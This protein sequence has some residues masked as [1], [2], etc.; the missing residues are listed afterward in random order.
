MK[1]VFLRYIAPIAIGLSIPSAI[2]AASA[3]FSGPTT[4]PTGGNVPGVIWNMV[5]GGTQPGAVINIDGAASMGSANIAGQAS[6]GNIMTNTNDSN[7]RKNI[8]IQP[9]YAFHVDQNSASTYNMGNWGGLGGTSKPMTF[10]IYGGARSTSIPMPNSV[11]G[12]D[13]RVQADKFCFNPGNPAD[14][15]FSWS[16]ASGNFVVKTGDTMTGS[17]IINSA[18]TKPLTVTGGAINTGAINGTNSV[19]NGFGGQ[20]VGNTAVY[21]SST[22]AVGIGVEGLG[23]DSGAG[24]YGLAPST[25]VGGYF[26]G[27]TGA[28]VQGTQDGLIVT[29]PSYYGVYAND[30]GN[31]FGVVGRGTIAGGAFYNGATNNG[32][33]IGISGYALDASGTTRVT[34]ST[35]GTSVILGQSLPNA[36]VTNGALTVKGGTTDSGAQTLMPAPDGKNYIRG[37][38]IFGDV[39]HNH[40]G[41][42]LSN[43]NQALYIADSNNGIVYGMKLDNYYGAGTITPG[44]GVG[45]LFSVQG[46]GWNLDT[47]RGKGAIVYSQTD[48]WGRGAISFLQNSSADASNPTLANAV[49]TIANNGSVGI[50]SAP[51]QGQLWVNKSVAGGQGGDVWISNNAASTLGNT[52]RLAFGVD[53]STDPTPNGGIEDIMT[54]T[55]SGAS[56]MSF[57]TWNGSSYGERMRIGANGNVGIGIAPGTNQLLVA[58]NSTINCASGFYNNAYNAGAQFGCPIKTGNSY[59]S[60]A[61][62]SNGNRV[63]FAGLDGSGVA[64]ALNVIGTVNVFGTAYKSTGIS[65]VNTSDIRLKDHVE[66]MPYGLDE[67]A[68][69]HVI[70]Y[71]FKPNNPEN[72]PSDQVHF[73]MSAQEV[74]KV[75][76]EA[77]SLDSQGYYRLDADPIIWTSVNAIK[78]LKAE[79]DTL[80]AKYSELEQRLN[81]LQT[82]IN[83][84]K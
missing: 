64:Y 18:G 56:D 21:A 13:G 77:V 24:F 26:S 76:P 43:P 51:V 60:V 25:G 17:L 50:G 1:R 73:G 22:G 40:V 2:F 69:L 83:N 9:T 41:I 61:N 57:K 35:D 11:L 12:E 5:G 19:A 31:H 67:L 37:D 28:V 82:E 80:K 42:G 10:T 16:G 3:V 74:L 36:I 6:A 55:V 27:G 15:I 53:A 45:I 63:D 32:A 75:I 49:M 62:I 72:L 30:P 46:D 7:I 8:L 38:T 70:K 48:T 71:Q 14:C 44:S 34:N 78:Q 23:T 84:L 47:S 81:K 4:Q 52:S 65:W 29:G 68:K 79:N 54:N 58:N 59:A 66:T 20:F 33:S 39:Y